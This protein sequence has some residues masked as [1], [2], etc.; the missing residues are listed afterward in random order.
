MRFLDA[1]RNFQENPYSSF[2]LGYI[3]GNSVSSDGSQFVQYSQ[4]NIV[5]VSIQYRLGAYGFLGPKEFDG[6]QAVQNAGLQDQRLA[7]LWIQN[8]IG[9]FGGDP[10]KVTIW[11][12]SAGGGSVV[13]QMIY[14]GGEASPPYRA[15]IAGKLHNSQT[16]CLE[17][18]PIPYLITWIEF[19]WMQPYHS[20]AFLESQYSTLLNESRCGDL[21]CLRGLSQS[22]LENS[23]TATYYT[24][25][26]NG[27]Y[28][29]GDMYFGPSIDGTIIQNLPS[30]EFS[31][32][33][34][35]K[36]PFM[37]NHDGFEGASTSPAY[38]SILSLMWSQASCLRTSRQ[39]PL[40]N[41]NKH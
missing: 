2:I 5:W 34:F 21:A 33:H 11:G 16:P 15:A 32:G 19:P 1:I 23:T 12:G 18:L 37:T 17:P 39:L 38:P 26:S 27:L 9:A 7:L 14:N 3:T 40:K 30:V 10:S 25:Y 20:D 29:Y 8:H 31:K 13:N 24:A 41:W 35:C 36:V 6:C 22:D 4:G 28:A